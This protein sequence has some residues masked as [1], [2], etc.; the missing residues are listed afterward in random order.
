VV[1]VVKFGSAFSH[2]QRLS[3]KRSAGET[4]NYPRASGPKAGSPPA[5]GGSPFRCIHRRI[6]G[7]SD[8]TVSSTA[9]LLS[10][11][12]AG[13]GSYVAVLYF[14]ISRIYASALSSRF[15]MTSAIATASAIVSGCFF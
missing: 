12:Y 8:P 2:S 9:G 5:A 4:V 14:M 6:Y 7:W 15:L 11:V 13:L 1:L 10:V 3:R